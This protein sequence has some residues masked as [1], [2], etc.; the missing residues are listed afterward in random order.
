MLFSH[1][2]QELMTVCRTDIDHP[3]ASYSMHTFELDGF[4]W[5]SVEH[6]FHA[7]RYLDSAYAE[8][9]RLA[10]HPAVAA[11]LGKSW[12]HKKRKDWDQ[13]KVTVMTRATYIKCRTHPEIAKLLLDSGDIEI[14]EVSQYDY[15][16]GC[17]RDL[18]GKNAYGKMLMDIR[19]K[20]RE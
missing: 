5:P 20:L 8:S 7:M 4:I 10:E 19:N 3:L 15:F 2:E 11:K 1:E 13:V 16:W 9:I 14:K 6:Y 12:W 18:R 17:G